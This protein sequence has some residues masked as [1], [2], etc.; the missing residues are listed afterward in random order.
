MIARYFQ[1]YKRKKKMQNNIAI[2]HVVSGVFWD[3]ELVVQAYTVYTIYFIKKYMYTYKLIK[4]FLTISIRYPP[5]E[6]QL[7]LKIY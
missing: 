7:L 1:L 4:F 2:W 3:I 6:W 5:T